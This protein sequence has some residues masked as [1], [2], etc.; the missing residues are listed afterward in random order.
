M[1]RALPPVLTATALLLAACGGPRMDLSQVTAAQPVDLQTAQVSATSQAEYRIGV[2][3]KLAIRV[4]QVQDLSF[5]SLTVDT[6][7][8]IQLPLIGAVRASDR[9][10][11]ELSADIATRLSAQYLRNPQVTVTVTEA[12]S[13]KITVDG[14]VTKPGV[15]EMRGTTSLLQ[16][17]AMAEGPS[18]VADLTKVAVFRTVNG[19]RSVALFDL[20][21]IRQ[22][23]AD[24]PVVLGD[25]IIVVDT[26]RLNS[27]LREVVGALPALSIFRPF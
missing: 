24:D 25:D 22:G 23:R 2:G 12:A 20:Q 14:A 6:S 15:Y 8:N 19:Q 17:V 27:A 7:G 26:S 5:D 11:G 3:D 9:T 10:A 4:F 1:M 18:R 21:A 13:Q 16:A